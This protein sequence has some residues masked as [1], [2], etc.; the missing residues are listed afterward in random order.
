MLLDVQSTKKINE[1]LEQSY[2]SSEASDW[3]EQEGPDSHPVLGE[4]R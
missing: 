1:K 3:R 2:C 4:Q